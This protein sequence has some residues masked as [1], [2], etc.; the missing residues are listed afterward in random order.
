MKQLVCEITILQY[1]QPSE[2]LTLQCDASEKG[3]GAVISQNGKPLAF[4]SKAF[5]EKKSNY[6]QIEK[7]LLAVL[8]GLEK[9]CQY[10]YSRPV[11]VQSDHKPLECIMKKPLHMAPKRL[12]RMFLRLQGYDM[13]L[14]YQ[15][16]K[17]MEL[18]DTL[19]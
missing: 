6:A 3:L 11:Q 8:F 7:E 17:N 16:G 4:A 5:L 13:D 14:V 18:S 12:Q 1:Y 2:E 19:S 15:S 9:F 10:T